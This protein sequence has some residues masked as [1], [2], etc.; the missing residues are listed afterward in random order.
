MRKYKKVCAKGVF[1][2]MR[3]LLC[4]VIAS[5]TWQSVLGTRP[6]ADCRVVPPRKDGLKHA[7]AMT[8]TRTS[9]AT[10]LF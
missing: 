5:V 4:F 6:Q 8:V 2:K 7:L 10:N 3:A 9:A 1:L